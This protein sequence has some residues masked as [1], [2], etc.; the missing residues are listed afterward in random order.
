MKPVQFP[1][2]NVTFAAD[3]PEYRNLPAFKENNQPFTV[4]SC[5]EL[6]PEEL[7]EVKRTG[8][9]WVSTLTFGNP[10]QPLRVEAFKSEVLITKQGNENG[11]Q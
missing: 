7:E 10:L 9:V 4:V 6:S 8:K 1:E 5:W 11:G 3:Q 2:Q